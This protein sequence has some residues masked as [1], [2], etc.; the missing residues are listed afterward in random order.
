MQ[1]IELRVAGGGREGEG[2]QF[3]GVEDLVRIGVADSGDD[4]WVGEGAFQRVVFAAQRRAKR[5][6]VDLQ[7]LQP[8]AIVLGQTG[9]ATDHIQGRAP[10]RPRLS[11]QQ[12]AGR[13]I[14]CREPDPAGDRRPRTFPAQPA[15]DHEVDDQ[16]EIGLEP[17]HDP[18][19]ETAQSRHLPSRGVGHGRIHAA[20]HE[21][22]PDAH[23]LEPLPQDV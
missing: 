17:D 11:E 14:E 16:V 4:A 23:G 6:R 15:R 2:G 10:A 18:F 5:G 20:Q 9:L 3:R 21:R 7:D 22:T 13:K 1:P 12:R 8:A 19:P